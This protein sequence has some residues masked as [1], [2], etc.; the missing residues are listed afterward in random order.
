MVQVPATKKAALMEL[1]GGKGLAKKAAEQLYNKVYDE[2]EA[3]IKGS[4]TA[5]SLEEKQNTIINIMA[6]KSIPASTY[7]L[8]CR[9]LINYFGGRS[10]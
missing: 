2:I 1:A 7:S 10:L 8:F 4:M 9:H 5:M 3:T 6:Q